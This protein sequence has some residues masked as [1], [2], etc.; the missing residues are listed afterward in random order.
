MVKK[1]TKEQAA[2]VKEEEK[3]ETQ[4]IAVICTSGHS[5]SES[6]TMTEI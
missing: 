2:E 5:H 4:W 6:G 1:W 3:L